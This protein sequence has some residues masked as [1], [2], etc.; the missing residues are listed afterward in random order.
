MPGISDPRK[1]PFPWFGGKSNA[2]DVIWQALGDPHHY[3]EPFCGGAAV[4]LRR[5]EAQVNRTYYSETINDIDGM[6]CNFWRALKHDPAGVAEAASWPVSECDIHARHLALVRWKDS[7]PYSRLCAD[8]DFY[9]SQVAGWWVWGLCGWIGSGWCSGTGPWHEVD[10]LFV[11]QGRGKAREPGV[12]RVLP[13]LYD[14]GKGVNAPQLREP[15]VARCLPYVGDN[16]R[17]VNHAG[18]R[19]PG[20]QYHS[21]VMPALVE[22]LSFL[23]ARLRHVR[24]T[25]GDWKRTLTTS[26]SKMLSVRKKGGYCGVFLDPPYAGG[27]RTKDIY[28][29][30]DH[31]V[32][33]KVREW[34]I[35]NGDDPKYRIVLAGFS[36]EG[37]EVLKGKHGWK[38]IEWFKGGFLVGGMGNANVAKG[39]QMHRDRLWLSPHCI[40][41]E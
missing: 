40:L 27:E 10:G 38:E 20:T 11:K 37:H 14:D 9:D 30:D 12:K 28:A 34:C 19:E 3:I 29:H 22:W 33:A 41:P 16:G 36:G 1:T 13:H 18:L 39:H 35:A 7:E 2:A 24:I 26:A 17:G 5:P 4:L 15:G 8:P 6:I 32:A 23:S 25:H 21:M 31:E